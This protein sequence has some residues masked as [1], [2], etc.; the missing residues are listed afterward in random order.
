MVR[1]WFWSAGRSRCCGLD[2]AERVGARKGVHTPPR[3]LASLPREVRRP[4]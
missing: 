2:S 1:R 4:A 3:T